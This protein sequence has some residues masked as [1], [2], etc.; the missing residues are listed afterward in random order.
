MK[1]KDRST[2]QVIEMT[3]KR[4]RRNKLPAAASPEGSGLEHRVELFHLV[5]KAILKL[6]PVRRMIWEAYRDLGF[7]ATD[8]KL[9][10]VL[11]QTAPGRH[12]TPASVRRGKQEGRKKLRK[13]LQ[14]RG[15]VWSVPINPS[16]RMA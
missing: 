7:C 11:S 6:S 12:W 14:K 2:S 16:S 3:R 8:E 9:L 10:E 13:T 5:D 1:A 4:R 15:D